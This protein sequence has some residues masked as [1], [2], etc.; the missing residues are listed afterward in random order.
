MAK[1][2]FRVFLDSCDDSF[3]FGP[4]QGA[5]EGAAVMKLGAARDAVKLLEH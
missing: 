2:F 5:V 4:V 3:H 1:V